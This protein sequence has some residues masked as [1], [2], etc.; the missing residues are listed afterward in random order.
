MFQGMIQK[1]GEFIKYFKKGLNRRIELINNQSERLGFP[2]IEDYTIRVETN[3]P[4]SHIE[5]LQ[6][7]KNM[8]GI[9]PTF[10]IFKLL[11]FLD[12][13]EKVYEEYQA[14]KN[15]EIVLGTEGLIPSVENTTN[16]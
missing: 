15:K 5:W 16:I 10:E 4:Q 3:I 1:S 7:L 12:D 8:E 6:Y 2:L 11:P 13:P 9:I 14:E